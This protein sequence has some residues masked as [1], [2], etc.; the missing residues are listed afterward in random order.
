MA[1]VMALAFVVAL[2]TMPAGK[3]ETVIE[4]DD[5]DARVPGPAT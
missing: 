4:G 3:V 2:L 5:E 1:A